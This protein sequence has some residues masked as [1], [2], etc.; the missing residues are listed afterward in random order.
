MKVQEVEI[1]GVANASVLLV[2]PFR[3]LICFASF[4]RK[5]MCL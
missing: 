1:F 4:Y 5:L 3:C 2:D